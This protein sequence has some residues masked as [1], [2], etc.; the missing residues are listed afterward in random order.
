MPSLLNLKE[1]EEARNFVLDTLRNFKDDVI[2]VASKISA[3]DLFPSNGALFDSAS[4]SASAGPAVILSVGLPLIGVY[5]AKKKHNSAFARKVAKFLGADVNSI[6][7]QL[8]FD[9]LK[10]ET[11]YYD[12]L[13]L[14]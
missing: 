6:N 12:E 8:V 10:G 1:T 4:L 7:E 11:G 14:F 3:Q 9:K 13:R 5:L 2:S